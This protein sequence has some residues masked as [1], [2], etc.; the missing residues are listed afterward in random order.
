MVNV[1]IIAVAVSVVG[2]AVFYVYKAKK[3]GQTC[4]GCPYSKQCNGSCGK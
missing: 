2:L 1:I 4:I 3:K